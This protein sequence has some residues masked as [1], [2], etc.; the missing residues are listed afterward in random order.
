[1]PQWRASARMRTPTRTL[2][3]PR[4]TSCVPIGRNGRSVRLL[5]VGVFGEVFGQVAHAARD[6]LPDHLFG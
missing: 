5:C 4:R 1:M 2:M 6:T 3:S